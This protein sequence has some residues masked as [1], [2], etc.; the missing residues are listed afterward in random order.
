M[1]LHF[2]LAHLFFPTTHD[3]QNRG[4]RFIT[5]W[6]HNAT[7]EVD[8]KSNWPTIFA[9]V[10]VLT[11]VMTTTVG[12]R[13]YVRGVMLKTMGKDDWVILFSAVCAFSSVEGTMTS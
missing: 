10:V 6:V 12:L 8:A 13:G 5:M 2:S 4:D 3:I 11:I 1:I 7:Q 9:V